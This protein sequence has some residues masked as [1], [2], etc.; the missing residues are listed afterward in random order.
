MTSILGSGDPAFYNSD[1]DAAEAE[2][3]LQIQ[4]EDSFF[5]GGKRSCWGCETVQDGSV[6]TDW[7]NEGFVWKLCGSCDGARLHL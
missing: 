3:K 6:M 5:E 7:E 4:W 2:H 1:R